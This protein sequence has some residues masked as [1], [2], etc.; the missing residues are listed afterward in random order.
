MLRIG[1]VVESQFGTAQV[2]DITLT[3]HKHGKFGRSV[4]HLNWQLIR[5]GWAVIDLDNGHWQY[6]DQISPEQKEM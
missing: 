4:E 1:S 6:G 2:V 3:D 5:A